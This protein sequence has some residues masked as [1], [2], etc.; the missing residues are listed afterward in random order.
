MTNALFYKYPS[1]KT[2]SGSIETVSKATTSLMRT[3]QQR[4]YVPN[5]SAVIVSGDISPSSVFLV[6]ESLF[7]D[8]P[9]RDPDPFVE[10]P[11]VE[12]PP[13]PKSQASIITKPIQNVVIEIGW[14]GPSIGKDDAATY[15]AD[16]FSRILDQPDSRFQRALVDEGLMSQVGIGY[17]TQRNVGPISL[18]LQTTPRN[19]KAAIK[20]V[21]AEIANFT[22]PGY[23]TDQ[24]LESAKGALE[25]EDL[26]DREKPSEYTHTVGFWWSTTG[27]DY[28]RG[29]L[30]RLRDTSRADVNRY[31]TTYIQN[32]PHV[33]I[34]MLSDAAL[35]ASGLT[36]ED[37]IGP[38]ASSKS[39]GQ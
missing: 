33:G 24:E 35:R 19:A 7:G 25:V 3:I 31:I 14:Q 8:W 10:F 27:L 16:V 37:L 34:A 6:A 23:F 22:S 39:G 11:L 9:K 12:H 18:I 30:K 15:A 26:F 1:R 4:Y 36:N 28:F 38:V 20:A 2:P 29:Y 32:K 5:N 13:L 17:Y 21:Y